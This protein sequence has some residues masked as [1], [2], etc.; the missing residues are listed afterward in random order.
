MLRSTLFVTSLACLAATASAQSCATLAITG[1]GAPGT[2]LNVSVDG[3]AGPA[4]VFLVAGEQQGS[5]SFNLGPLG[6]LNL[7][8]ADVA[9]VLPLGMADAQGDVSRAIPIPAG[10]P[11]TISV[12]VFGQSV[13]LGWSFQPLPPTFSLCTSNVV[14]F[15]IG[16]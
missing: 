14:G 9:L 15:H 10:L 12:D 6:T 4:I 8:L 2:S 16:S 7:G 13:G 1:T 5:L 11:A 3:P